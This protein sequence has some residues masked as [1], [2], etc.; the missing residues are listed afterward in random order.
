[1]QRP[2]NDRAQG[3]TFADVDASEDPTARVRYLD[4]VTRAAQAY[5]QNTYRMIDLNR[6]DRVLDIGCGAG[7]DVRAMAA[8][9]GATG[10]AVGVD[11]SRTMIEEARRRSR[12]SGQPGEFF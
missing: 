3:R 1:M 11:V 2:G 7:D 8:I 5:K 12:D 4:E 10:R 6:G 9:V